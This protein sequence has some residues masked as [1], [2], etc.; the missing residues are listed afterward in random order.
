MIAQPCTLSGMA[1]VPMMSSEVV[2]GVVANKEPMG[3]YSS[4]SFKFTMPGTV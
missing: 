1:R 4:G 2:L 3:W